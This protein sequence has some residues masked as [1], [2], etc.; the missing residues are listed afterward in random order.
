[1]AKS[2]SKAGDS[3]LRA[4]F[5][6][7]ILSEPGLDA[8]LA[9]RLASHCVQSIDNVLAKQGLGG[10]A[11]AETPPR[12]FDPFAFSIVAVLSR[13]G[14]DALLARLTEIQSLDDL[15]QLAEAQHIAV[16]HGVQDVEDLRQAI[17]KGAER[18]IAARRAA[19][20]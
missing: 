12:G 8:E 14:R 2:A 9:D 4:F 13:K 7:S 20:S 16:D 18:R 3:R 15:R 19:A 1:M 5:R 6:N 17:L 11:K 10:G